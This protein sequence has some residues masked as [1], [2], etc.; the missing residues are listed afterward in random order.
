VGVLQRVGL[1]YLVSALLFYHFR[2]RILI[3]MTGGLLL[4]YWAVMALVPIPALALDSNTVHDAMAEYGVDTV[5]ETLAKTVEHVR[6]HY[7]PG[8][9]VAHY[10]D[11]LYLPG[12]RYGGYWDP[13]GMLGT[14][15]A[16]ATCMM[17]VLAG[18]FLQR[19]DLSTTQKVRKLMI[20][21]ILLAGVGWGWGLVFPVIKLL[22]TSSFV[23]VAAG[24]SCLL[25]AF[26]LWQVEIKRR[27]KWFAPLVWV[28]SNALLLYLAAKLV[29]FGKLAERIL[30]SNETHW[31]DAHSMAGVG[32]LAVALVTFA[33]MLG[34]AHFLFRRRVFVRL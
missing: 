1:V 33:L 26:F 18:I 20:G 27:E 24:Y 13:E 31:L 8:L 4:G 12:H 15:P 28:G 7:E 16:I 23:L 2:P 6:G 10:V 19:T 11:A 9:N 5:R 34:L 14:L 32:T 21:G 3:G 17:G 22:W 29:G 25:L 30:S